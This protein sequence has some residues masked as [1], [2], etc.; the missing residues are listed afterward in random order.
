MFKHFTCRASFSSADRAN[1]FPL[2]SIV[3]ALGSLLSSCVVVQGC[4]RAPTSPPP[5]PE[6]PP[7]QWKMPERPTCHL[8]YAGIPNV[9]G[10]VEN[11]EIIEA[12]GVVASPTQAQVLWTHNDSGDTPRIFAMGLEG[13]DLAVVHIDDA[14]LADLEDIA[15]AP[16]PDGSGPC[17]WLADTGNNA[18]ERE[19]MAIYVVEEPQLDS[20]V[21]E[22]Q[23]LTVQAKWRYAVEYPD[24]PIN[25]EAF[26]VAPDLSA[27]WLIEKV[28]EAQSRVFE[29]VAPFDDSRWTQVDAFASP[30]VASVEGGRLITG[31]DLH[32]SGTRALIRTYTGLFEYAFEAGQSPRTL[33]STLGTVVTYGPVDE[34]QGEAIGYDGEGYGIWTLSEV[35][36]KTPNPPL[37]HF[38]CGQD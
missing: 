29:K 13:Q 1:R 35:P 9:A 6:A 25:S 20:E 5:L 11:D 16:C 17:L 38:T 31:A 28:D 36:D 26:M 22:R 7:L 8:T 32:P 21:T 24:D 4:Q 12:S 14:P 34:L 23:T 15:A 30:G 33:S 10:Q 37:H 18:M 3:V 27:M 2:V 19:D